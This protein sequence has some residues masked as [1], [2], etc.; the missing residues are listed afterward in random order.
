MNRTYNNYISKLLLQDVFE[1]QFAIPDKPPFLVEFFLKIHE[2]I[3]DSLYKTE[4]NNVDII[5]P[6][7]VISL[8]RSGSTILQDTLCSHSQVA[9]INN[10]MHQFRNCFCAADTL[11]K[12]MNLNVRGERYLKDSIEVDLGSPSEGLGFWG[13]WFHDDPFSLDY[14]PRSIKNFSDQDIANIYHAIRKV[15]WCNGQGH[16]FFSKNPGLL[17]RLQ[18]I[19]ELFPDAKIIHLIRDPR[20]TA[21]SLVKLFNLNVEQLE[22]IRKNQKKT[23]YQHEYFIPYPRIP[24]LKQIIQ[25]YG[26]DSIE[27]TAHIWNESINFVQQNLPKDMEVLEVRHEDILQDPE[28]KLKMIFKFC[29][30][31]WEEENQQLK[32]SLAKIGQINHKNVY[33]DYGTIEEICKRNLQHYNYI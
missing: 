5:K 19:S 27:A 21:N 12:K 4:I 10:T 32:N 7:F 8:P 20:P 1:N 18:F 6:I 23:L 14:Q 13:D 30:L 28:N 2:F 25:E 3:I 17:P 24:G 26:S 15:I 9:Y 33:K 31:P 11:R 29:E 22:K 16:R